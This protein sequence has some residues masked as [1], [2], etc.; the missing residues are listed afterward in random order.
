M[1]LY[2][3]CFCNG[4]VH[5]F[6]FVA[7][8][9]EMRRQL[10]CASFIVSLLRTYSY[11]Q[12]KTVWDVLAKVVWVATRWCRYWWLLCWFWI[13]IRNQMAPLN[14]RH[15]VNVM[16]LWN[17]FALSKNS[18]RYLRPCRHCTSMSW[19]KRSHMCGLRKTDM[20]SFLNDQ[21]KCWHMMEPFLYPWLYLVLESYGLHWIQRCCISTQG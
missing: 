8:A 6:A 20:S 9:I 16:V 15:I 3:A 17:A 12:S 5:I 18:C 7:T 4:L 14:A 2:A 10:M 19:I 21:W 13:Q 1:S 11:S